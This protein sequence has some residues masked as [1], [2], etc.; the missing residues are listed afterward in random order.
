MTRDDTPASPQIQDLEHI[1]LRAYLT[2]R[3]SKVHAKLNA[4]ATRI[5][6]DA[7]GITLSQ[8]RVIAL[9]GPHGTTRSADLI[10]E[11]ALDKGLLS[12]NIKTLVE[13]GIV[14]TKTDP[15]DKRVQILSLTEAGQTIFEK[16][17]PVTQARQANLRADLTPD[18]VET[19]H[20]VLD[21]LEEA[22]DL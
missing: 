1:P 6:R 15:A 10:K 4:Q 19:F 8:W 12:R 17:L 16:T 5:L 13:D 22:A 7:S 2:F 14:A 3:I 21:K 9:I 11:A 18:E 20:R